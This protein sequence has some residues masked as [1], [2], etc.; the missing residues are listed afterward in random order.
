[1]KAFAIFLL[2]PV[3]LSGCGSS[4]GKPKSQFK[5]GTWNESHPAESFT[6]GQRVKKRNVPAPNEKP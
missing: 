3:L 4:G 1:M 2:L 6:F 5:N